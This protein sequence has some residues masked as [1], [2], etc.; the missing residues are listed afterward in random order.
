LYEAGEALRFDEV[1]IRAGVRGILGVMH[2]LGMRTKARK[3]KGYKTVIS[4]STQWIRSPKSGILRSI[5]PLGTLVKEGD[6]LAY[7]GDPLGEVETKVM[8]PVFGIV[9]GKTNLPLVHEGDAIY[10]IARYP[11]AEEVSNYIESYHDELDPLND[12]I[13]DTNNSLA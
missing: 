1:A 4:K 9:I 5:S 2:H 11:E 10:H 7:V 6:L 13:V 8:S 12:E 3:K